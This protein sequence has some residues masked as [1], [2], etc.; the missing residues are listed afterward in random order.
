ME[1]T[2][3]SRQDY[4]H[5]KALRDSSEAQLAAAEA[6]AEVAENEAAYSILKAD[7]D[8]TVIETRGEP[9]QVVFAGQTVV[10]LAHSGP[11]EAVVFLPET[12][13]PA[14][15]SSGKASVYGTGKSRYSAVLRQLSDSADSQ[16]RTYEAR[17]VLEG[18][19]ASALLGSTVTIH[20]A[21]NSE[22]PEVEVPLGAVHDDGKTTGIWVL[23]P[24]STVHFNP[25]E[26]RRLTE[27]SALITGVKVGQIIVALGAHLLSE[28]ALVQNV[29]A[30]EASR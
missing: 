21:G 15:Q 5:A 27:E 3:V 17:Y 30:M 25:V 1:G 16:T 29:D 7:A 23:N 4:E 12:V 20:L 22:V 24:D 18:E 11:R 2:A 14:L 6:N 8:G 9:G 28:G 26:I 13:R 10:R 19:A